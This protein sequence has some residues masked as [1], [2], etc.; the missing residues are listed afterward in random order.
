MPSS[1]WVARRSHSPVNRV[2]KAGRLSPTA[3]P[4]EHSGSRGASAGW[5]PLQPPTPLGTPGAPRPRCAIISVSG[6]RTPT[7]AQISRG[8]PRKKLGTSNASVHPKACAQMFTAA[9]PVTAPAGKTACARE[10]RLDRWALGHPHSAVPLG[11]GGRLPPGRTSRASGRG[12]QG[13]L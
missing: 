3:V 9:L 1:L 10:E 8:C 12:N 13:S 5:R 6:P 2:L 4:F 7:W 11:G